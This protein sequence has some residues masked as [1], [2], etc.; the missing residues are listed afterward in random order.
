MS[1]YSNSQI[2]QALKDG[3][4]V[5]TPLHSQNLNDDYLIATLG[6]SYYRISEQ[7]NSLVYNPFNKADVAHYFDGAHVA[8]PY[9][10][11][12]TANGIT[13]G[14]NIPLRH[15]IISIGPNERIL[16][17][18]HE[19]IGVQ[20]LNTAEIQPAAS[21]SRNGILIDGE[22]RWI[23]PDQVARFAFTLYNSNKRRTIVLPVGEKIAQ[24]IFWHND[25]RA[26]QRT[27][28]HPWEIDATTAIANWAPAQML[29][30][31]HENKRYLPPHI[32]G[33]AYN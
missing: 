26:T 31:M 7:Q 27:S 25:S 4:I 3:T 17:H 30:A 1:I 8:Q 12:C 22:T 15:P 14:G 19:F 24:I 6:Y 13:P 10:E 2:A 5:C 9:D 11:W 29:P 32:E 28:V 23:A 21:W 18:T 16:V 33:A 20:A